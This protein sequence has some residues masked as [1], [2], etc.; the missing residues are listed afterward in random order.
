[1]ADSKK[2]TGK[3]DRAR[4]STKEKYEVAYEAKKMGVSKEA[5]IKAAKKVGPMRKD[6][7]AALTKSKKKTAKKKK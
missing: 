3:A 2:K 1:M 6:I 4:V 5:V 7:E